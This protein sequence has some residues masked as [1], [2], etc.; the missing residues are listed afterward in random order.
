MPSLDPQAI[1]GT[2]GLRIT[3]AIYDTLVREDLSA[4]T[5]E[6]TEIEPFLAEKWTVSADATS[7]VFTIRE[8][9]T[10]QDGTPLNAEAVHKNFE[11]LLNPD[12][13]FYSRTAAANMGFLT[14]WIGR[15]EATSD[16]DLTITLKAP[17]VELPR[18]LKDRRMGIISPTALDQMTEEELATH[19]VGTGPFMTT[20]VT[21]G[22]SIRLQRFDNYWRGEPKLESIVFVT[23]Q[24]PGSMATAMQTRQVDV[25]LSAGAQQI[26]QLSNDEG[27]TVQYPDAANQ[28][29]IRLNT[30]SGPTANKDVRQALNFA[31]NREALATATDGQARPLHGSLPSGNTLWQS[32]SEEIYSHN[33]DRAREL[34][35]AAGY[36]DG[37]SMKLLAPSAGPGFSQSKQIMALVQQDL[38]S[39]GVNLSVEY[40]D[41]TTLVATEG[42]GYTD[43]VAGSYNGWTT[44]ADNAYWLETMFSPTLVPPAGV[45]RGWYVNDQVGAM[46]GE[47]RGTVDENARRDLYRKAVRQIDEDAPWIFLYQDRLP[48]MYVTDVQ[49]IN[50]NPSAFVDYAVVSK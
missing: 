31:I 27:V 29:F 9:V 6:A 19:P 18:L 43:G 4:T 11:R 49:G 32:D 40:M 10:F 14:R 45:N 20:G 13:S 28:Y 5:K 42:P 47:A 3:D 25:I 48:R 44:G 16:R 46:F 21:P 33:P 30:K 41:F 22:E 26:T 37:F 17:F 15:T 12:A 50:E 24:D 39:V 1:N 23:I 38:A 34:L 8:G 2:V 36:S 35:A 7:Y